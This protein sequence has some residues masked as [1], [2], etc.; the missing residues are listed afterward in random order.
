MLIET[1]AILLLLVT[2]N[3]RS[4]TLDEEITRAVQRLQP[5]TD[6]LH[7]HP[8][9]GGDELFWAVVKFGRPALPHLIAELTN[10]ARTRQRMPYCGGYYTRADAADEA[11]GEIVHIPTWDF[12]D[13]PYR[14][15][16]KEIGF[17]AKLQYLRASRANR[18]KYQSN[19]REW[20]R[21]HE[22]QLVW[23][24]TPGDSPTGGYWGLPAPSR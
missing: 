15:R 8:Y 7:N 17:C 18:A 5:P 20:L 12:L 22:S 16:T 19:V 13:E 3:S 6:I 1:T 21:T 23:H 9:A 2:S 14:A 11:I 24:S 4:G 10:T